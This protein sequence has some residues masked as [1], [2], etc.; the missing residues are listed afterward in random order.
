MS[1]SVWT[2]FD[3]FMVLLATSSVG[4][5]ML[6]QVFLQVTYWFERRR[7]SRESKA[8]SDD[9]TDGETS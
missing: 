6:Q 4:F 8:S 7:E 5:A 9:P 3:Y 2:C 1:K